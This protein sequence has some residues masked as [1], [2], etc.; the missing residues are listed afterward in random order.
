MT[1]PLRLLAIGS[2]LILAGL[3]VRAV[4]T[5]DGSPGDLDARVRAIASGLRC[6]VCQNLSVGDSP[7]E[8]ARD[9]RATIRTKLEAGETPAEIRDFFVERYGD[10]IVF[11]PPARG[12]GI[13]PWAAPAI[14]TL[15]GA[16][17]LGFWA[18]RRRRRPV[19]AISSEDRERVRELLARFEPEEEV[20]EP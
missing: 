1:K 8:L 16:A 12:L 5:R 3:A 9:M 13:V 6:P 17:L 19:I 2:L 14:L 20:W 10:W 7:S 15:A 18:R 4:A 11:Q